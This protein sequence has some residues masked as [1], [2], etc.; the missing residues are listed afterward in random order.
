MFLRG[1]I[2]SLDNGSENRDNPLSPIGGT[3]SKA[4]FPVI[5]PIQRNSLLQEYEASVR[6]TVPER[7]LRGL[8]S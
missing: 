8:D 1:D 4:M 6:E 5:S 7:V 2:R 3:I